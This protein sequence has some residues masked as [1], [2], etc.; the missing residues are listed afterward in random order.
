VK[1][2]PGPRFEEGRPIWKHNID[3][4]IYFI[5]YAAELITEKRREY[6]LEI[7]LTSETVK[8]HILFNISVPYYRL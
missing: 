5:V 6:N 7:Y 4:Y 1:L 2:W 8:T 3:K